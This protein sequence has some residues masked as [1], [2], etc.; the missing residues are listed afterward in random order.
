MKELIN[1]VHREKDYPY[2]QGHSLSRITS[3]MIVLFGLHCLHW[4]YPPLEAL[5]RVFWM[6][7]RLTSGA[8]KK[9]PQYLHFLS[10]SSHPQGHTREWATIHPR[11]SLTLIDFIS[12]RKCPQISDVSP[13]FCLYNP[14][15]YNMAPFYSH[16]LVI[17]LLKKTMLTATLSFGCSKYCKLA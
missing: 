16:W 12:P 4:K 13:L 11:N 2:K 17:P 8:E 7:Q 5:A 15:L 3:Y 10:C 6:F 14:L 1:V 9:N